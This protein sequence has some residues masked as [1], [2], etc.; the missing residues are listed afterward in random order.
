MKFKMN[1]RNWEIKEISQEMFVPTGNPEEK[2]DCYGL[3][4]Y[5]EQIIYLWKDLHEEQKRKTLMHELLHCY[6]GCYISFEDIDEY[7][8]DVMCNICANSHDII[9]KICEDYFEL[10]GGS[11]E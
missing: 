9:H 10:K 7:N 4:A 8:E 3:C 6:I 2:G 1:D 5:N 11:D